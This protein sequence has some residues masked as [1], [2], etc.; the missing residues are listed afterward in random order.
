VQQGS[1]VWAAPQPEGSRARQPAARP[2]PQEI[3]SEGIRIEFDAAPVAAE[4]AGLVAGRDGR[5]RFRVSDTTT[6]TPLA[7]LR[8]SAWMSLREGEAATP[9]QCRERVRAFV[10]GS[11]RARPDVD[12]NA[13]YILALNQEPNISVIDPLLG[14]GGSKL[15]T[16]IFLRSPGA[17]WALTSD[18]SKLFVTMPAAN[19]VAVVDTATWKV[20]ANVD[21]G[22]RP[23]RARL[24]PDEKYLWVTNAGD[25]T[26]GGGVTVLDT[27]AL[28]PAATF[29]A[30]AGAPD[31]VFDADNKFAFLAG[32]D[33]MLT[34]LDAQRLTKAG[35]LKAGSRAV[36]V[37]Y[38][39]LSRAVYVAGEDGRIAVVDARTHKLLTS[40]TARPGLKAV[41]FEPGGRY[42]FAANAADSAVHVFDAS[43]NRLIHTIPVGQSPDQVSFTGA[44]A[45]V[46]SAGTGEVSIVRL[47]SLGKEPEVTKFPGGQLAPN[48]S[49]DFEAASDAI[50][51]APEGNAVLVANAADK[52]IYYYSEGMAAPMGNFQNY[53]RVPRAVRVVDRS[54][55]EGPAGTYSTVVKPPKSG[56]YDVAFLL[57]SPRVVHC[58]RAEAAPNPSLPAG[59]KNSLR[60]EYVDGLRKVQAGQPLK[61]RFK[62]HDTATNQPKDGLKDVRVLFFLAPGVWQTR[63]FAQGVG[64]GIYELTLTPPEAG[65]YMVFVESQSQ[66]VSFRQLPSLTLQAEAAPAAR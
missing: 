38:S 26:T 15:V 54:L 8:P 20:T 30:G 66:G 16:L 43:T 23:T 6:K 65:V 39:P 56:R 53:K 55:R 48:S 12:L 33:G 34:V 62:L 44:F 57:D 18:R 29:A 40:I 61:L 3:V 9:E 45:Y 21:A 42:G 2:T 14:F 27:A 58:F 10:Q 25:G 24:Q 36:S 17:D 31:L 7:G 46:R 32:S 41:R 50:V 63:N 13:Y 4:D 35:E 52:Q 1:A 47:G 28:K 19:Q 37:A 11:L 22:A 60:I 64:Q 59:Q 49:P 5:V 51:P